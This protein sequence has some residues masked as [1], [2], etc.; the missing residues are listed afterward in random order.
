[1]TSG[2]HPKWTATQKAASK[3]KQTKFG[4]GVR[5]DTLETELNRRLLRKERRENDRQLSEIQLTR[6]ER[7]RESHSVWCRTSASSGVD[8]W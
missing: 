5:L 8:R 2:L 4:E 1:M 7:E 6:R 3:Y